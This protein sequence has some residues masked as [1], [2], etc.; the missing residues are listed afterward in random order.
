MAEAPEIPELNALRKET[1]DVPIT[2]DSRVLLMSSPTSEA[3]FATAVLGRAIIRSGGIVHI[4]FI[5]PIIDTSTVS[6]MLSKYAGY[7]PIFIGVSLSTPEKESASL[8]DAIFLAPS[9]AIDD[10]I[11]IGVSQSIVPTVLALVAEKYALTTSDIRLAAIGLLIAP[12]QTTTDPLS[13][14]IIDTALASCN[15]S[16]RPE[17]LLYGANFMPAREC[18]SVS[19]YPYMEG[20]S[21]DS[22]ECDQLLEQAEITPVRRTRPLILLKKAE[23]QRI[24]SAII[25]RIDPALA[26]QIIGTNVENLSENEDSPMR[27]MSNIRVLASIAWSRRELGLELAVWMGDRARSL[28]SL[29]DSCMD[30]TN[31]VIMALHEV[32]PSVNENAFQVTGSATHMVLSKGDGAVLTEV[33]RILLERGL[34]QSRFLGLQSDSAL[35]ISWRSTDASL[36]TILSSFEASG[37]SPLSTSYSSVVLDSTTDWQTIFAT[38]ENIEGNAST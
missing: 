12:N 15:L 3:I 32:L 9:H 26:A 2:S 13:S 7:L 21:G 5:E 16:R 34:V 1:A 8:A 33:S 18:L 27:W 23:R 19:I 4:T 35:S 10:A 17:Y 31:K 6:S 37:L 25:E 30:T 38:L 36:S 20:I 11:T 28:K 14:S 24:T 29:L 22:N